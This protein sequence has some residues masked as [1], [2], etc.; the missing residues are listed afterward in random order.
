MSNFAL[1]VLFAKARR[2]RRR[3]IFLDGFLASMVKSP[4]VG[5]VLVSAL[6]P[7]QSK[8]PRPAGLLPSISMAVASVDPSTAEITAVT[9]TGQNLAPNASNLTGTSTVGSILNTIAPPPIPTATVTIQY[10]DGALS[11]FVFGN[12]AV[13]T[14]SQ[15]GQPVTNQIVVDFSAL[16]SEADAI[17]EAYT[18]NVAVAVAVTVGAFTSNSII[19]T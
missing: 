4:A 12:Q 17:T 11:T 3:D 10:T 13:T 8:R 16:K 9:I 1:G 18:N 19:L 2:V 15:A 14:F 6:S 5:L 7:G